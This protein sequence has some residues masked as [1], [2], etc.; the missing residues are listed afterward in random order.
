MLTELIIAFRK[1]HFQ[2][3]V[4]VLRAGD[5]IGYLS[6]RTFFLCIVDWTAQ[7]NVT[8]FG[9]DLYMPIRLLAKRPDPVLDLVLRAAA[10]SPAW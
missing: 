9:N 10:D 6:N 8:I 5:S 4:H 2:L 1:R 3:V 7:S